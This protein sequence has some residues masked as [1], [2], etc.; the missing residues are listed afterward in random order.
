[1]IESLNQQP[2]HIATKT[3]LAAAVTMALASPS[4]SVADCESHCEN[5]MHSRHAD[6]DR[7][8]DNSRD[9]CGT[10]A[11]VCKVF[12]SEESCDESYN[13][14]VALADER[15]V[16]CNARVDEETKACAENPN[17]WGVYNCS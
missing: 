2:K 5:R 8:A 11:G 17:S 4:I 12:F 10:K 3:V 9:W 1:M 13:A 14:C 7:E 6:C 16:S 15:Q